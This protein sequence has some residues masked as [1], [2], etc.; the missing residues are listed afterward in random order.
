MD[1][2]VLRSYRKGVINVN[3][4]SIDNSTV[5]AKKGRGREQALMATMES[6]E[7]RY[8]QWQSHLNHCYQLQ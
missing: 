7:A 3:N 1:F 5:S 4:L 6:K 2:L 8:M